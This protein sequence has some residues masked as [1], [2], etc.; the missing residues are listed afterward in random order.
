[1]YSRITSPWSPSYNC[2]AW[3]AGD[4]TKL[5]WPAQIPPWYWPPGVPFEETVPAF[6]AAYATIGYSPCQD[7]NIEHGLEKV[8]LFALNRAVKH[9][10]RQLQNGFWTSKMGANVDIEHDLE[11]VSG[12]VYG[13]PVQF[14]K[15][16]IP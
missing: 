7:G 12:P 16:P 14:L 13:Q 15:R 1:M 3:A 10:A 9:A 2:I 6:I 11:A 5:W 8:V 4:V